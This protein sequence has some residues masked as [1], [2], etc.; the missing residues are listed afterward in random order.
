MIKT[1][2]LVKNINLSF[3]KNYNLVK[4]FIKIINSDYSNVVLLV[5][6]QLI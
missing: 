3:A 4:V 2:K 5:L 1:F 6:N